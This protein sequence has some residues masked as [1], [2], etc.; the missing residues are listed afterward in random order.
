M[1]LSG[2]ERQRRYREKQK[3]N[4]QTLEEYKEKKH[5][6][7]VKGRKPI[8]LSNDRQKRL[9]RRGWRKAQK[10]RRDRVKL[11]RSTLSKVDT[12]VSSSS[13][14][15]CSNDADVEPAPSAVSSVGAVRQRY[16]RRI[17]RLHAASEN[18]KSKL[19]TA[20]KQ[21]CR[22]RQKAATSVTPTT[23]RSKSDYL[24]SRSPS[25][26]RHTLVFH[27][28]LVQELHDTNSSSRSYQEK[29]ILSKVMSGKVLKK[30]KL[31]SMSR[32]EFGLRRRQILR[33][34]AKETGLHYL[35]RKYVRFKMDDAKQVVEQFFLEDINSRASA[36]KNETIT[37][38]KDKK[39]KRY[40]SDTVKNLH[41]K[42]CVQK[43]KMSYSS[44][45]K[46]RPFWVVESMERDTCACK[47]C[48]NVKLK[49]KALHR[50]GELCTQDP[51]VLLSQIRCSPNSQSCM[52]NECKLCRSKCVVF[53]DNARNAAEVTWFQWISKTD[54]RTRMQAGGSEK[55]FTV[56]VVAKER[57]VGTIECL[58]KSLHD[59]LQQYTV[60]VY[61]IGHQY[62]QLKDLREQLKINECV[63]LIDF[64]ENYATKYETEI[65][66]MHFGA[67]RKQVTLH[68]GMYYTADR[69]TSF[70]TISDNTRHDPAAIWAHLKPVLT[71]LKNRECID[72]IHF[73]S[74]SP[75][76][77]YRS[78][79][80][81]FLMRKLIHLEYKFSYATWNFTEASHGKG[82]A[83]GVGALVKST[84]DRLVKLGIDIPDATAL[85]E[86]LNDTIAVNMFM[87]S[88]D[89]IKEV[90]NILPAADEL[91][92]FKI[93]GL[94]KV[95]QVRSF[96]TELYME[97]RVLSCF[98]Q[99]SCNCL[100]P[101][102]CWENILSVAANHSSSATR[103]VAAKRKK[104]SKQLCGAAGTARNIPSCGKNKSA[105]SV[106]VKR[107]KPRPLS[108]RP[109]LPRQP[110]WLTELRS[111]YDSTTPLVTT[112]E[113]ES[114]G[115]DP[116]TPVRP[117]LAM[118]VQNNP[119]V[120]TAGTSLEQSISE[121]LVVTVEADATPSP[122]QSS[123]GDPL[124]PSVNQG[125][126]LSVDSSVKEFS[127]VNTSVFYGSSRSTRRCVT[128]SLRV[129]AQG[130]RSARTTR[131]PAKLID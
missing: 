77:Q 72:T 122:P 20:Q 48:E 39:Q 97:H 102:K 89:D 1:P 98:C 47:K 83:D 81:L 131:K 78:V 99:Q 43:G 82:P 51:S 15:D 13:E 103:P 14:R 35:P 23:P 104:R 113:I 45:R 31:L 25:K 8:A 109:P 61:N 120:P 58:K 18:L 55:T 111:R 2:A 75:S 28:A 80:N 7:Y 52:Y 125:S 54:K 114:V 17:N 3:L 92:I 62:K 12:P 85:L 53:T 42:F 16:L 79:K 63:V 123:H 94:M 87:I 84:A 110:T 119:E 95:H 59:D 64:S 117:N 68:T 27:H 22:L 46:F 105:T 118:S 101:V 36:G 11:I 86:T 33:N 128:K 73:I 41:K 129:V 93:P 24:M 96:A 124:L 34:K 32:H 49:V 70:C 130:S 5:D 6:Y 50:L 26:V 10:V 116:M 40:L 60:H 57:I 4:P 108:S 121:N 19:R 127:G 100:E 29:Q 126:A 74:D 88:E 115:T 112:L 30:Y 71:V 9:T 76:T 38:N 90:D 106:V 65:Q 21:C 67:S 44:F 107:L 69:K 37:R 91:K 56:R 66:S